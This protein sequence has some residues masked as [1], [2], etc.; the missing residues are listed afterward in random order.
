MTAVVIALGQPL[1]GDDA[2]ALAVLDELRG[3]ELPAGIELLSVGEPSAL[4]SLLERHPKVIVIDAL[5]LSRGAAGRVQVLGLAEL[6]AQ[7]SCSVSS[8]GL[9]VP[10]VVR[11]AHALHGGIEC[12]FVAIGIRQ[13]QRY[14]RGLSAPVRAAVP[15]AARLVR[16][17]LRRGPGKPET[18]TSPQY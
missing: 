4:L 2:V 1:A 13:P 17:L 15:H 18:P 9:S 14:Q 7:A 3:M 11:L 8:H 6:E 12:R 5:L 16:D 10:Q